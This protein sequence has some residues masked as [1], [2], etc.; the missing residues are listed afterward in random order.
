MSEFERHIKRQ[1]EREQDLHRADRAVSAFIAWV[2]IGIIALVLAIWVFESTAL[3]VVAGAIIAIVVL[4]SLL[5]RSQ[6]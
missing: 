1:R 6:R 2:V 3:V 5:K 4:W